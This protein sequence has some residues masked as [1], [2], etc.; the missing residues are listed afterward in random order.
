MDKHNLAFV[1]IETTG[2]NVF[3]H[4]IIEVG[5]VLVDP[6]LKLIEEF[7]IKIK[8]ENIKNA[9]DTSLKINHYEEKNWKDA[10]S[11]TEAM[12]ILALKTKD[13]IMVGHNIPFDAFFLDKA[14]FETKIEKKLFHYYMLDTVSIAFAKLKD[15]KDI[16]KFTL[17]E[18]CEFFSVKNKDEHSALSDARA[19]F[20]LY[21]KLMSL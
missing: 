4:E 21:K 1:D 3:T 13:A 12:K 6:S 17:H 2:L 19:T 11:L 8:P 18:L 16:T 10:L 9:D 20:E 15:N 5:C 7:E 14:F